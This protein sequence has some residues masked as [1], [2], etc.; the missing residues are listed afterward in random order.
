MVPGSLNDVLK[1]F[2]YLIDLLQDNDVDISII[3]M[4]EDAKETLEEMHEDE[5]AYDDV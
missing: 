5:D 4:V 2:D 3:S 1:A